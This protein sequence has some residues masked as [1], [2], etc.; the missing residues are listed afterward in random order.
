MSKIIGYRSFLSP[1]LSLS[2]SLSLSHNYTCS[3]SLLLALALPCS[4]SRP[5]ARGGTPP[6]SLTLSLSLSLTHSLS[7]G[8]RGLLCC[9][10]IGGADVSVDCDHGP[11][12]HYPPSRGH[13]LGSLSVLHPTG[14]PPVRLSEAQGHKWYGR[15]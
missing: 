14:R 4:L 6:L 9:A 5:L 10:R 1:T 7:S 15:R 12:G 2:L 8:V 11:I 3:C 13:K